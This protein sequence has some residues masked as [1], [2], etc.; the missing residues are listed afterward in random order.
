MRLENLYPTLQY[1]PFVSTG[2]TFINIASNKF[3]ETYPSD[4]QNSASPQT[5]DSERFRRIVGEFSNLRNLVIAIPVFGNIIVFLYDRLN[6]LRENTEIVF[7]ANSVIKGT[8]YE[9]N[10]IIHENNLYTIQSLWLYFLST[11][12]ITIYL[13]P[14][15]S[16]REWDIADST[17]Y[18]TPLLAAKLWT[19]LNKLHLVSRDIKIKIITKGSLDNSNE[20][21]K[22]IEGLKEANSHPFKS[23]GIDHLVEYKEDESLNREVNSN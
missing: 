10:N 16:V 17:A 7:G 22:Q 2:V 19:A 23:A 14:V 18:T 1:I 15:L 6:N 4:S 3:Y 11:K 12:P 13:I 9:H 20:T 8:R 5:I 21:T